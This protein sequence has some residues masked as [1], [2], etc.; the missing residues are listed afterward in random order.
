MSSPLSSSNGAT[1]TPMNLHKKEESTEL[2][3]QRILCGWDKTPE[4][5][6]G[7]K[8]QVDTGTLILFWISSTPSSQ[9]KQDANQH[10]T[11]EKEEVSANQPALGSNQTKPEEEKWLGHI[12]STTKLDSLN[13]DEQK[14]NKEKMVQHIC[15]LFILPE[16]R[17]GGLA[18][19]AVRAL[20]NEARKIGAVAVTLNALSRRYIEDDEIRVCPVHLLSSSSPSSLR[21]FS[22]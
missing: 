16:H 4:A 3:R 7:W 11:V 12:A 9:N 5:I 17:G 15:N 13:P 1:L 6:E 10:I 22:T 21:P 14:R 8:D 18:S 20:E 19:K 2:L